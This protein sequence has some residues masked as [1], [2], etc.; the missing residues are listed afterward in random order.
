M[1]EVPGELRG[2][3]KKDSVLLAVNDMPVKLRET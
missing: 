1:F 2:R 3:V